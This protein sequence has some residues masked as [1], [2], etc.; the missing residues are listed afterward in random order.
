M[1]CRQVSVGGGR[2]TASKFRIEEIESLTST[3]WGE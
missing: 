2:F 3:D 1:N